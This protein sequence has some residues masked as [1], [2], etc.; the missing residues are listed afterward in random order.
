MT[1]VFGI[2]LAIGASLFGTPAVAQIARVVVDG[3]A[4]LPNEGPVGYFIAEPTAEAGARPGDRELCNWALDDWVRHADGKLSV[5]PAAEAEARLRVYFAA[6]GRSQY[7]EMVGILVGGVRGAE[8]YVRPDT[9]ALSTDIA[10]AAR[11]D[12]LFRETVVYLTCLHEIGHALGLTHT[13]RFAD[14]MY[15]FGFGG[16][17]VDFFNVYRLQIE[18]RDDIRE[19]SG[20]SAGDIS[21]LRALWPGATG[22]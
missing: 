5:T 11:E 10:D 21:R 22:K 15:Y 9:D 7:G 18:T 12:P 17:I 6:P 13:D 3:I 16:D 20:L 2:V 4:P 14:I 1:P 19:R 8:V